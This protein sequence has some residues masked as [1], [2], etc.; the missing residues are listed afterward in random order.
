MPIDTPDLM[1]NFLDLIV[2]LHPEFEQQS[3]EL[4]ASTFT[5][6]GAALRAA[7]CPF[8]QSYPE[9][10]GL[11]EAYVRQLDQAGQAGTAQAVRELWSYL[12]QNRASINTGENR[13]VARA[14]YVYPIV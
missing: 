8:S 3:G 14:K 5:P 9:G 11:L 12:E 13:S 7:P 10:G 4:P 6:P 1:E 2:P